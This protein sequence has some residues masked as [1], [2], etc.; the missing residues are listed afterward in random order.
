VADAKNTN[1]EVLNEKEKKRIRSKEIGKKRIN[2][3]VDRINSLD[4]ERTLVKK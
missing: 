4:E 3:S 1:D 2:S